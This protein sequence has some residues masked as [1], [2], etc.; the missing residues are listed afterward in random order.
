VGS[1]G[2]KEGGNFGFSSGYSGRSEEPMSQQKAGR[3]YGPERKKQSS[4]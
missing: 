1:L 4:T 3:G 2:V